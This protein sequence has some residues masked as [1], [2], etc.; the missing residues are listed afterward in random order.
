MTA[1]DQLSL[2]ISHLRVLVGTIEAERI[3]INW[4]VR[5]FVRSFVRS[6]RGLTVSL[7]ICSISLLVE[8]KGRLV[9]DGALRAPGMST[10]RTIDGEQGML[11]G[12]GGA[13]GG[14]GAVFM[15]P[16]LVHEHA[17][18]RAIPRL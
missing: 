11:R 12:G 7:L 4:S 17:C 5:S 16:Q 10:M 1:V 9:A 3:T 6:S 18:A 8:D 13:R 2:G 14:N 15:S